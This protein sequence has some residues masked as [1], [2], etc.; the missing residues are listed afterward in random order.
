MAKNLVTYNG[1]ISQMPFGSVFSQ[2]NSLTDAMARD[3]F[4]NFSP[5]ALISKSTYPKIDIYEDSESV[6]IEASVPGLNRE[7]IEITYDDETENLI[8]SAQNKNKKEGDTK[9]YLYRELHRS[10]FT[11]AIHVLRN[12]FDIEKIMDELEL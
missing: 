11:R 1:P 8:L 10:S 12:E 4:N 3:F 9:K 7:D 2:F 6:T 5:P